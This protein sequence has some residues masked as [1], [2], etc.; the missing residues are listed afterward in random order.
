MNQISATTLQPPQA[1]VA[2]PDWKSLST[3][4]QMALAERLD[5]YACA[6][7]NGNEDEADQV[8][9]NHPD[10]MRMMG[11]HI[12]SLR[13]L[14]HAKSRFRSDSPHRSA[15]K[16]HQPAAETT[17]LST[18]LGDYKIH[19]EIGRG[20]MGIVY[21][22]TQLS[23][24]RSVALKVLPFAA[25]LDQQ[26]VARFRNE[27]QAAASLH[28]PHIVPVF[29]VGCER[30]VHY[31]SMQLI[32][33]Q[34][35]EQTLSAMM[36]KQP[37]K[38]QPLPQPAVEFQDHDPAIRNATTM[39]S[40]TPVD[41]SRERHVTPDKASLLR[42]N[43]STQVAPRATASTINSL[44]NRDAIRDTVELVATVADALDYAHQQ[45]VVH[46]DIKPSNLLIDH[47]GKVWV[48]DF[49]LAR[50]RGTGNLTAEGN[51]M[52]TA[53]YMSPEQ[54]SGRSQ[55]VDHRTDIYSLGI[56]LYELLTLQP[57]FTG[58]NR[59]QLL[60]LVER[61]DP[62]SPRRL[63]PV[64]ATDLETVILKSIAKSKHERYAT[65]G[66]FADDLRRFLDGRPTLARR[67][68]IIDLAFNWAMRRRG[69]VL[70]VLFTSITLVAGL[71][72][73]TA[74]ISQRSTER[75]LATRRATHHLHQAHAVVDRFGGLMADQLAELPG[76]DALR[77]DLLLEA[78]QYYSDFLRYA[79]NDADLKDE[80]AK[81]HYRLGVVQS[82]LAQTKQAE[83]SYRTAISIFESLIPVT[84]GDSRLQADLA[85]CFHNLAALNKENGSYSEALTAYRKAS[86]LQ[87]NAMASESEDLEIVSEWAATQTNLG[88]LLLECGE[89]S[90]AS[91]RLQHALDRLATQLL[92]DPND[93]VAWQQQVECRNTLVATLLETEPD[94]AE[95]LLRQTIVD[96]QSEKT[97]STSSHGARH[98]HGLS[99]P[100]Q[101]AVA[102]N[103]LATLL[104]RQ[105]NYDEAVSLAL[106]AIESFSG[107]LANRPDDDTVRQQL[108]ITHNNH[109]QLLWS[110]Q[111]AKSAQTAFL[112]AESV[113]R[114]SLAVGATRPQLLSRLAG[115]IHN[116][117]VLSM[118]RGEVDIALQ[119]LTDAMDLQSQAVRQAPFNQ[120][121]RQYLELH[122]ELLDQVLR[123]IN[124]RSSVLPP[125]SLGN[126][127]HPLSWVDIAVGGEMEC[128]NDFS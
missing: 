62:I 10:L 126:L 11:G 91:A 60:R 100:C 84:P 90:E 111:D 115:V 25:V 108:A 96:L 81:V 106:A 44:A 43:Q 46:R 79:T 45:G 12:E 80:L 123:Q 28:H 29:A 22:A 121:Y 87:M 67:P 82:R 77:R 33:G 16:S 112:K 3:R 70:G 42:A 127:H 72:V 37:S 101:L 59:E 38:P 110:Q 74:L 17:P 23:L 92:A 64:I 97:A 78:Q 34:T 76:G 36:T 128:P 30:G 103:N 120:G 66:E 41:Q 119:R 122:R 114:E 83:G 104:G 14:C 7:E 24:R 56:T 102:R 125:A 49:G 5:E 98:V 51:V 75:D 31:Y 53:R 124:Q 4:A 20:G 40:V 88:S 99:I 27:A 95:E 55:E 94:R 9:T 2:E 47:A 89:K 93:Q 86:E 116:L 18:L 113:F 105:Q 61:E 50:C 21:E 52:G 71:S 6:L 118:N 65:A 26:Q 117:G 1:S 39:T 19:H 107:A 32:N 68:T 69:L 13:M 85:L 8:L 73:A 63:N 15:A 57:A 58:D 109:G 35:L 54:I 48:A